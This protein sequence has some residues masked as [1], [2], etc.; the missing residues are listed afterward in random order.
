MN[1]TSAYT[2]LLNQVAPWA[3]SG[4]YGDISNL[5]AKRDLTQGQ[6]R[7]QDIL[8]Q[9]NEIDLEN[10]KKKAEQRDQMAEILKKQLEL[11]QT[12]TLGDMYNMKRKAAM[13]S[14]SVEDWMKVEEDLNKLKREQEKQQRD[15][16]EW[17]WKLDKKNQPKAGKKEKPYKMKSPEDGNVYLIP[18]SQV[19]DKSRAGW[20]FDKQGGLADLIQEMNGG[21]PSQMS[22]PAETS[23]PGEEQVKEQKA[24]VDSIKAQGSK[25][26]SNQVA[27]RDMW[28][29]DDQS[30]EKIFVKKGE[31]LP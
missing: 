18:E 24:L 13:E 8:N 31:K 26:Q 15:D 21:Q 17:Q 23:K 22:V 7:T 5:M 2:Q 3:L 4:D 20:T 6:V 19:N 30:G 11:N 9:D 16:Q 10:K 27:P 25:L 12:P 1:R 29:M 14:G 28:V